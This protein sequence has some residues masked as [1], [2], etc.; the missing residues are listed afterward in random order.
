M[1]GKR[2]AKLKVDGATTAEATQGEDGSKQ[3][4]DYAE[5]DPASLPQSY[6]GY[7]SESQVGDQAE[8]DRIKQS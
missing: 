7:P 5:E 1:S 4:G 8:V 3:V 6:P 2:S